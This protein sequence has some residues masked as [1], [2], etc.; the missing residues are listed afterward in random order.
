LTEAR[1]KWGVAIHIGEF[2]N[3]GQG[4]QTA[5]YQLY[6]D[7]KINWNMWTYKIAGANM[8]N[9]SL[10]QARNKAKADPHTDSFETIKEKWG[11]TLR[12]FNEGTNTPANGYTQTGM[13]SIFATAIH[14]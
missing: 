10:Y 11:E 13:Y 6:N 1:R 2:N 14:Y 9:W 4:N 8:G 3:D 12:T 7:N 5:A